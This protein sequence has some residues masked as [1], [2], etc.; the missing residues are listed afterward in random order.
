M[1]LGF[2]FPGQGSQSVGMLSHLAAEHSEVRETFS[3]ASQALGFDLWELVQGGPEDRLNQTANTQP[4][5]LTA[6]VAVWRVW[7]SSEGA[8][9]AYMAGH[10][11]G[12]YTALVCGGAIDFPET[13]RL[14]ADRGRFMQDAVPVG[15]GGMAAIMG[16]DDSSVRALCQQAAEGEV[17]TPANFNAP[18]Q[19]VIAGAIGA[20]ERAVAK[21]KSIGAKRAV[22]L[23][24][25][26]P[27]HCTLMRPAAKRMARRLQ[28]IEIRSPQTPVLHNAHVDT[29]TDSDAIRRALV[30]QV[31]SP[32]RWGETI[33]KMAALGVD[34]L[35]ECGP[36]KIL[37]GLNKRIACNVQAL[38]VFDPESLRH[39][40]SLVSEVS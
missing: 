10:S 18:D 23:P 20:V 30:E 12:E 7:R 5:L 15:E 33:E 1:A 2:V 25:S 24:V 22:R 34:T 35:V 14:V 37:S 21:A 27:F 4:A 6:G 19:V 17:L 39:A 11:L 9:P 3:E 31:A 36:G 38:P 16:L 26:G 29:E 32:V 40:L 28:G 13:V 8:D